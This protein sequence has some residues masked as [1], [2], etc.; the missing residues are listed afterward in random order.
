MPL[1]LQVGHRRRSRPSLEV[2][3]Y[4]DRGHGRLAAQLTDALR[5]A[6]LDGRL[7]SGA[8]VP[9][10][11]V[12]AGELS[13][14]RT[15]T[16]EAYTR[17]LSEGYLAARP[18]SGTYVQAL[19][20]LAG[21]RHDAPSTRARD[22]AAGQRSR[23]EVKP[24][25]TATLGVASKEWAAAW[26]HVAR[27]QPPN[28]YL[29]PAGEPELREALCDYLLRS[30]GVRCEPE[31]VVITSGTQQSADLL[32]R[33]RLAAGE[34]FA[35]EEPGDP[36]VFDTARLNNAPCFPIAVDNDGLRVAD[37]PAGPTAPRL[38]HVAPSHQ[39]PLGHRMSVGRRIDMVRWA[40]SH[41]SVI[42]EDDYD[43]EFRYD[44]PP[45]PTLF[46]LAPHCVAYLGTLSKVLTPALRC[47]YIVA[48]TD[49]A[50]AT[51]EIKGHLDGSVSW[52][53]QA[54]IT[55][56]IRSG[57]LERHIRRMRQHYARV[58]S[59][60]GQELAHGQDIAQVT[61]LVAGLHAVVHPAQ[62]I[63]IDQT[64]ARLKARGIPVTSL[65][66]H[67]QAAPPAHGLLLRYGGLS[68][69]E[70]ARGAR[71]VVQAIRNALSDPR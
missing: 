26:R 28:R 54:A 31:M 34:S 11:R 7:A 35:C 42:I 14:S 12:L 64:V 66:D 27:L 70:A 3:I 68:E 20:A 32:L 63:D 59:A 65:A 43:S 71:E 47:G 69:H 62:P 21:T 50:R 17:L 10:T 55:Y 48:G 45:F 58:R 15:V 8:R 61:G 5:A 56:L 24:P 13:V 57:G 38:V 39:F 49:L 30:R 60:L 40:E 41:D 6:I 44:G 19:G 25:V 53:V 36:V 29:D 1:S 52:P 16:A 51:A 4:L 22:T 37:L 2:P 67:Y 33:T 18:G 46:S 23:P 9:S